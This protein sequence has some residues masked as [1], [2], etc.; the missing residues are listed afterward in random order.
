MILTFPVLLGLVGIE[1]ELELELRAPC[2]VD[3]AS[4]VVQRRGGERRFTLK[5]PEKR[6][7]RGGGRLSH[8]CE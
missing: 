3:C 8:Y 2:I 6:K 5:G 4:C 1:L 7:A